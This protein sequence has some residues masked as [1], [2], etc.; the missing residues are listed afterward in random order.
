MNRGGWRNAVLG[1]W[2]LTFIQSMQSGPPLTVT[3]AGSPYRYLPGSRRPIQT[4]TND[5]AK[6]PDWD[7]GPNRFPTSAQNPY[8]N[9]GA[10]D[11]PAAYQ[12]G[13]LG[14]N[15]ISAPG[16]IWAQGSLSKQFAIFERAKFILRW[17]VN[18]IFKNPGFSPPNSSWDVRNPATF[19]RI[20]GTRANFDTIGSRF[21]NVLVLRLE[22]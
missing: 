22:W 3:F 19:G 20:T 7:I 14:R 8:L 15:T 16:I 4:L 9:H 5:Q 2:D 10:Y 18:N 21:H 13:T 11:Y 6:T 17:D 12:A 1:G